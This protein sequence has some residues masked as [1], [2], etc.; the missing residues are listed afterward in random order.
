[1]SQSDKH[2]ALVLETVY[3]LEIRYPRISIVS[4]MQAVPG[5]TVP[6]II[7]GFRPDVYGRALSGDLTVIAE[8][9]TDGDLDNNHTMEQIVSFI[10]YLERKKDGLF[11]LSVTGCRADFSKT[12]MRFLLLGME[13]TSTQIMVFDSLDFWRYVV[14]NGGFQWRLS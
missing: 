7:D 10:N 11:I 2:R 6:P 12:L 3:T 9:K 14:T 5:D 13:V 8:A 4:D 1:M